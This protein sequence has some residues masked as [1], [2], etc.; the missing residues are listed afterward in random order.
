[1]RLNEV[2]TSGNNEATEMEVDMYN[3][4]GM[5]QFTLR[6]VKLPKLPVR[7]RG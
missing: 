6:Y 4:T 2:F 5:V 1:M 7:C 3:K